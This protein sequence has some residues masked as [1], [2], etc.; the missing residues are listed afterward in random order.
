[1]PIGL[2]EG[3]EEECEWV[4]NLVGTFST[5]TKNTTD[6]FSKFFVVLR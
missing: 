6:R 3:E 5:K 2:G 1:M 4:T